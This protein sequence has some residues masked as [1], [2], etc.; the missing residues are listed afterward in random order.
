[1]YKSYNI[2]KSNTVTIQYNFYTCTCPGDWTKV[3][4][5]QACDHA[6]AKLFQNVFF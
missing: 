4:Q 2:H 1:M 5:P 6:T 3:I